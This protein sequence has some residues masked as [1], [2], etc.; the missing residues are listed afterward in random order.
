M[1]CNSEAA[2]ETIDHQI[3]VLSRIAL[4]TR[5]WFHRIEQQLLQKRIK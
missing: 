1:R 2:Q 5:E 4:T 3:Q